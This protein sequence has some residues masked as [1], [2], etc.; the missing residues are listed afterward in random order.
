MTEFYIGGEY[1]SS[2]NGNKTQEIINPAT[3]EVVNE[4]PSGSA[5][6]ID[7]AVSAATDAFEDW[8]ATPG[9][10]RGQ[11]LYQ[12]AQA[13]GEHEDELAASLTAEQGKPL[14][15]AHLE[16]R[17]FQHTLE[18][19]AGLGKN[20]RGGYVP[21]LDE[22][23][24][25]II[26]K[27]PLGVVG[28]IVPW[29]FPITLM[30]NKLAPAMVTGNTMVIK[31]AGTT[32]LTTIRIV[33]LLTQ[34][35]FP[36]G[37]INVVTGKGS[38]VG[39]ALLTHPDIAKIGF[40]GATETGRMV[41]A[42]AAETIKRVTLELG[43]SDPMIVA[44]DADIDRAV[45]AASVGRFFNCG[46]ACLAIKRV[47]VFESIADEFTEKLVG[48]VQRLK[49]GPGTAQGIHLGPMH[50]P[51]QRDEVAEQVQDA[52]DRGATVLAGAGVPEGDEYSQGNY[53][54]PTLLTDVDPQARVAREEVFGPALPVFRVKDMDEAIERANDSIFGL[55][56][57]VWTRDL[58]RAMDAARRIEAGYTWINSPQKIYDELPFG[59][60]KQSGIG[61]E[62]GIEAL[63][64]Y[65]A[66]K[67]VVI[68]NND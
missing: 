15:E 2:V 9:A 36:P 55:G 17:R 62:H 27:R 3:N 68:K 48:K 51:S 16:I 1:V 23:T 5:E 33:E 35:G 29:N 11:L 66:T 18:H 13:I 38:V 14:R 21:E 57:S 67:S 46:Q 65:M 50:T 59:G 28:A 44:D 40:T 39:E 61:Q 26:F 8:W 25:G 45:S 56:S 32:P 22:G 49:V 64:H 6:D 12:G 19:Y 30:G 53:Y 24:Q 4:V 34:A 37:V 41:M 60:F 63:E 47:F 20:L 7:A 42:K 52:I 54:L 31:P 10:R 58:D 43:G